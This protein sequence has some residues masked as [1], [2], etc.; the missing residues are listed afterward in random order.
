[1]KVKI[2]IEIIT[3]GIAKNINENYSCVSSI[4][5]SHDFSII[6][7]EESNLVIKITMK[8]G[9]FIEIIKDFKLDTQEFVGNNNES[10]IENISDYITMFIR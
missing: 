4:F 1:M 7:F 10:L 3:L 5:K 2:P 8:G 9:F 6:R